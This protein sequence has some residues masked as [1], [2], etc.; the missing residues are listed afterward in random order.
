MHTILGDN[1]KHTL[2]TPSYLIDKIN[3]ELLDFEFST[4]ENCQVLDFKVP[5]RVRSGEQTGSK[6]ATYKGLTFSYS[7]KGVATICGS[8]HKYFNNGDNNATRLT[9]SDLVRAVEMLRVFGVDPHTAKIRSFEF[10]LNLN[11]KPTQLKPNV[12]I[13]SIMYCRNTG[14]KDMM[15]TQKKGFGSSYIT[16]DVT[17]KFYDKALQANINDHANI[18]RYELKFNRM[19]ALKL[20]GINVLSDLLDLEKLHQVFIDKYIKTL[21]EIIFF[22]WKQ[23]RSTKGLPVKYKEKF[24]NL[25]NPNWWLNEVKDRKERNR[26]KKLLEKI[27]DNHAN[28]DVKKILKSLIIKE[29]EQ[30]TRTKIEDVCTTI[31]IITSERNSHKPH[32][33]K[34]GTHAHRIVVYKRTGQTIETSEKKY[35][36]TCGKEITQQRKG[37]KYCA[38]NRKCRDKAY[39]TKK[40][41]QRKKENEK[42]IQEIHDLIET[43]CSG[44]HLLRV[45]P[46]T[47]K[48]RKAK[49]KGLSSSIVVRFGGSEYFYHGSQ[50]RYFLNEFSK[51][52]SRDESTQVE[53]TAPI[54]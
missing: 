7:L 21:D 44:S 12:F 1:Y 41:K 28:R 4:W 49:G 10:G 38:D 17:Y 35:C 47:T 45:E 14:K 48:R 26:N 50:A 29:Y 52:V 51:R 6:T 37:S 13:D 36:L 15:I 27:I 20:F 54:L 23:I 25:R 8:I 19:R 31:D 40:S 34:V 3:I 22:E 46:T 2:T 32:A 42:T 9:Y 30:V 53:D 5:V 18:L 11:L 43:H 16:N 33:P 39:N 24:K